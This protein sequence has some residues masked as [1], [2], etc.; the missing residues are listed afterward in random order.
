[1]DIHLVY[2]PEPRMGL[3]LL[4]IRCPETL[5]QIYTVLVKKVKS[6]LFVVW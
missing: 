2:F 1:M 3:G 4:A 5:L 6:L